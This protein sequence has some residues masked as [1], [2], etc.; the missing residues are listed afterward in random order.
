MADQREGGI[1]WTDET[2]NPIRGC[3]LVS[4]GCRNC[5]AMHVAARFNGPGLAYEGLA[6]RG[7]NGPRWTGEIK[8]IENHLHDPL[9]WKRPRMIFVNSMS[10]LFHD[11]VK[12][13]WLDEIFTV[14][15]FAQQHTFQVLT[16][17][18]ERMR[19]YLQQKSRETT[20]KHPIPPNVW[21]G[22]S[23]E[24]Q[25]TVDERIPLLL[26]TPAAVRW[27]SAEPL[28]GPIDLSPWINT[29]WWAEA[30]MVEI[31]SMPA[32][33]VIG[34]VPGHTGWHHVSKGKRDLHWVVVGG[35]SGPGARPMHPDWARSLRDQC[36]AAGVAYHFKQWGAWFPSHAGSRSVDEEGHWKF[37]GAPDRINTLY[38]FG[39]GYGA[40]LVGKHVAGRLLD[41]RE[42]NE[43]PE[44]RTDSPDLRNVY[45]IN[46]PET[47]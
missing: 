25:A 43:V 11:G 30:E 39:D 9:H 38:S 20:F 3:S 12:E 44:S 42:W 37:A 26:E 40:R 13:E 10:D 27:I 14:M 32:N 18:P 4:E 47:L 36:Q 17:R 22:V 28:L 41:G 7:N 21:W 24:D 1:S 6:V 46:Q 31:V 23:V 5:Y 2:W 33:V 35:E 45:P 29:E 19:D 16:K 34:R 15:Q 8:L